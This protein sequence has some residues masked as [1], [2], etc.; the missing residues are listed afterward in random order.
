MPYAAQDRQEFVKRSNLNPRSRI[1]DFGGTLTN[2]LPSAVFGIT[3]PRQLTNSILIKPV[4]LPFK[5][6]VFDAVVSYHY[7]D[8]IPPDMLGHVFREIARVLKKEAVFSF[9][10]L[11]W[12]P[13]NE[14]QR[15]SLLFNELLKTIG[16]IYAHE[17][18]DISNKLSAYGFSEITVETVKREIMIPRDYTR[19]HLLMLGDLIKREKEEGGT[20]IK[21]LA[22]QYFAQVNV[23]GEAMMPAVHF[24]AKKP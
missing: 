10:I 4:N 23:S 3:K 17:F 15:S 7:L 16:A 18:E 2:E 1:L 21:T 24:M 9:M 19:S 5:N 12:V 13:R 22:R 20:G 6:S 11:L 8:L 14:A